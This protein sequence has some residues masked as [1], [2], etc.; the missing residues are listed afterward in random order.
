MSDKKNTYRGSSDAQRKAIAKYHAEKVED[1][2]IRVPKGRKTYY[3]EQA[4]KVG[5]SLN[6]FAIDAM[7]S[8]IGTGSPSGETVAPSTDPEGAITVIVSPN[9]KARYQQ[10]AEALGKTLDKFT[11]DALETAEALAPHTFR[12]SQR[13][14][15]L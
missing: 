12:K 11:V 13:V 5:K 8:Q 2:K 10:A 7:D 9:D 14:K 3:K 6:Q 4:E 15:R 1:I